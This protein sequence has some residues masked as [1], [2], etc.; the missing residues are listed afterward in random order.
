M[1][2]LYNYPRRGRWIVVWI[3]RRCISSTVHRP[4]GGDSCFSIYQISWIK[5]KKVTFCKLK[6]SLSRNFVYNLL[7]FWGFCQVHF[8][9]LLQIQPENNFPLTSEHWQAKVRRFLGMFVRLLHLSHKFRLPKISRNETPSW[10]RIAKDIPSYGSESK[11]PKIAIH[12]FGK[13]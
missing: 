10:L 7:T 4:W 11:R 6:K 3:Y 5:P 8:T 9:I 2:I 1:H 12:W 13:Y